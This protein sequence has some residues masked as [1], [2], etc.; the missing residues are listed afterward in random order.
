MP[1]I[2]H[3]AQ[4]RFMAPTVVDHTEN[5]PGQIV[6]VDQCEVIADREGIEAL[7]ICKVSA[8]WVFAELIIVD[9]KNSIKSSAPSDLF[10]DP[11][12]NS[13]AV[14]HLELCS[15]LNAIDCDRLT[16]ILKYE[17]ILQT[18]LA[19]GVRAV[20]DLSHPKLIER[21]PNEVLDISML[22]VLSNR[23]E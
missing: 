17:S 7:T 11:C 20:V 13:F 16:L 18:L 22:G 12:R 4:S 2:E 5:K 9:D 15:C 6:G 8:V 19:N 21:H 3:V 23:C 14:R 1:H 10:R